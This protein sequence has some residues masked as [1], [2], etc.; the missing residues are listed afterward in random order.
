MSRVKPGDCV[1]ARA[2]AETRR[3]VQVEA[4]NSSQHLS[5][6]RSHSSGSSGAS[7]PPSR[8]V[9]GHRLWASRHGR[10]VLGLI[11]D[12]DA[13]R[14]QISEGRR[15]TRDMDAQLQERGGADSRVGC[16]D[17][18]GEACG[19]SIASSPVQSLSSSLSTMQRVLEEASRLLKLVWRVSLPTG[20]NTAGDNGSNQQDDLLRNEI[21]RLK[22]RL[23]H[24]E[25]LLSG[26]VKR[27][28]TTNQLKEGMERVIIDQRRFLIP[29]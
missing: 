27:L 3:H 29:Q 13:L 17:S 25:R 5:S 20:G 7:E 6:S 12:H 19:C 2:R 15:L 11:E 24:Q 26:A 23:S 16:C 4:E 9:P 1:C 28:R 10:H 18:A 22:N 21:S 8:L 14:K